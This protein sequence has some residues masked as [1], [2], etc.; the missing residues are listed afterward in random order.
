MEPTESGLSA[1]VAIIDDHRI[2]R[3][4]LRRMVAQIP[5][6]EIVGD[7][8]CAQI[9]QLLHRRSA[10]LLWHFEPKEAQ[11]ALMWVDRILQEFPSI[12]IL[13]LVH[14]CEDAYIQRA[15]KN[16]VRGC[17]GCASSLQDL[18]TA[19]W[20]VA[21]GNVY[22]PPSLSAGSSPLSASKNE[23]AFPEPPVDL[24]DQQLRVLKLISQGY[25]NAEIARSLFI[26]KRTVEMHT[27]RLFKRLN[28]S[29][30]TQAVQIALRLGMIDLQ[31]PAQHKY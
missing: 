19:L 30:R 11:A 25:S 31:E 21:H 26:S 22:L 12:P 29:S 7:G 20:E 17:L 4:A 3:T 10:I 18:E 24:P 27:Y 16:G 5:G 2:L 28:V 13:L 15:L 8:D 1:P 9:F 23:L 6:V 14:A